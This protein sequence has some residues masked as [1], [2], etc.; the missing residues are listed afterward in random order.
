MSWRHINLSGEYNFADVAKNNAMSFN[1][2]KIMA[3][4][5]A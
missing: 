1:L 4:E 2:P 5:V 3:L